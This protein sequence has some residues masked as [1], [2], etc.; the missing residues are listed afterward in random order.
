MNGI[1]AAPAN[2]F[3]SSV[4]GRELRQNNGFVSGDRIDLSRYPGGVYFLGI[5]NSSGQVAVLK[6]LK[7]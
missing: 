5:M 7:N 1:S 2:D 6:I 3:S 4:D